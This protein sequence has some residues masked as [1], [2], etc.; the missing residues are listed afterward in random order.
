MVEWRTLFKQNILNEAEDYIRSNSVQNLTIEDNLTIEENQVTAKVIGIEN[1]HVHIRL[2]GDEVYAMK[3]SCP[4]AK[5]GSSCKHTAAVML[6][7]ENRMK[8]ENDAKPAIPIEPETPAEP[9]APTVPIVEAPV[10]SEGEKQP[11]RNIAENCLQL[12]VNIDDVLTYAIFHNGA[13]IVRDICVKNMSDSDL[14]HL[15]IQISS[16]I[17]VIN[18]FKLGIEKIKPDEELHLRNLD[19]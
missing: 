7:W 2:R 18:D 14:E 13:H 5:A 3:C 12:T 17:G 15:L 10:L 1:Y 11:V 8:A 6:A 4:Y 16:D 19:V 9:A